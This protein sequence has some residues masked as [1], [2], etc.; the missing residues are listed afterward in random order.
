MSARRKN[1]SWEHLGDEALLDLRFCDLNLELSGS[2]LM[3]LVHKVYEELATRGLP[4]RPHC[5]L[6]EEWFTPDGV[7]GFAVPFYLVHPRLAR[8]ERRMMREVEGGNRNWCLRILRHEVAHAVDNAYRLRRRADWRRIFGSPSKPYPTSY[9][10]R[11]GSRRYVQHLGQ[12]YAQSHPTEDYAETFAVW[13]KPRSPWREEYAD[14][15]A[16]KKLEYIDALMASLKGQS[17]PVRTR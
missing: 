6:G 12:W 10:P 11:P 9:R 3:A 5:W 2:P 17:P 7:P 16:L 13:L 14:W 4:L 1:L 15:P 8:L